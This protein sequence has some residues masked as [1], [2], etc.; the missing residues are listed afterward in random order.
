[1]EQAEELTCLALRTGQTKSRSG[2]RCEKQ[3]LVSSPRFID[4]PVPLEARRAQL[5]NTSEELGERCKR[6]DD[7]DD[8]SFQ[9]FFFFQKKRGRISF[10][11][12]RSNILGTV[13]RLSRMAGDP[14]TSH[15]HTHTQ[16][17]RKHALTKHRDT[18]CTTLDEIA[19]KLPTT[20]ETTLRNLSYHQETSVAVSISVCGRLQNGV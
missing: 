10:P 9:G 20:D 3:E 1:M 2:Q 17:D 7:E 13:L 14:P 4:G 19:S 18:P 15:Q 8:S 6:N 12:G 5:A 16:A 11:S